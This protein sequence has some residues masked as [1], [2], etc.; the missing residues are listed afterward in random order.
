MI[1]CK[2]FLTTRSPESTKVL[3]LATVN[4]KQQV[5][6]IQLPQASAR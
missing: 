4:Q 2:G 6:C 5:A 1:F 3:Q